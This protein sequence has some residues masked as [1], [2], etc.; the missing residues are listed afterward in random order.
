MPGRRE[1]VV[2]V[3]GGIHQV[4]DGA[5]AVSV[6]LAADHPAAA[7]A[8]AD[9]RSLEFLLNFARIG[10]AIVFIRAYLQQQSD[11]SLSSA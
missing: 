7:V 4:A 11:G 10:A 3:V 1:V 5:T 6:G 8:R 2:L 9:G